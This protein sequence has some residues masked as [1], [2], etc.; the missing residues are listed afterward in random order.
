MNYIYKV[1]L[2]FFAVLAV[3][4]CAAVAGSPVTGFLVT[5][6]GVPGESFETADDLE[7]DVS[8]LEKGESSAFSFLGLF[9]GGDASINKAANNG[10]IRKIHHVDY[11]VSS[12]LGIFASSTTIV[13]GQR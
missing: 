10:K 1:S 12:F 11:E 6:V 2:A 9:A 8:G 5:N 4:S 7:V 13:Y 3:P